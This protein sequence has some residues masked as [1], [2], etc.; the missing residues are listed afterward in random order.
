MLK[1]GSMTVADLLD[2]FT[3]TVADWRRSMTAVDWGDALN[4]L[5]DRVQAS[6][7]QGEQLA[8]L[9]AKFVRVRCACAC[10]HKSRVD[11]QQQFIHCVSTFHTGITKYT[12]AFHHVLEH[13]NGWS[14]LTMDCDE[15]V[16]CACA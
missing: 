10:L 12:S 14:Y 5:N 1:V 8:K 16:S 7:S 4:S 11:P 15:I 2:T 6:H 13:V 3:G 9:T